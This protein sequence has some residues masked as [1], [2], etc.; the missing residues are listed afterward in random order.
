MKATIQLHYPVYNQNSIFQ[1]E[2]AY[3]ACYPEDDRFF[4]NPKTI[5]ILCRTDDQIV[6]GA[7]QSLIRASLVFDCPN[8]LPTKRVTN[9]TMTYLPNIH[10]LQQ[11]LEEKNSKC[12]YNR[13]TDFSLRDDVEM[14]LVEITYST[15]PYQQEMDRILILSETPK[16]NVKKTMQLAG[17]AATAGLLGLF[18][19]QSIVQSSSPELE[20]PRLG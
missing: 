17:V 12:L 19:Y 11:K 13:A 4:C 6:E 1:V 18:A 9:P 2:S 14:N 20:A 10:Q 5:E 7:P 8:G 15:I 16:W 3:L